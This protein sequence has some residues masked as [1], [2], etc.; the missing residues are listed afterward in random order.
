[1]HYGAPAENTRKRFRPEFSLCTPRQ[2]AGVRFG[3][4]ESE[5]QQLEYLPNVGLTVEMHRVLLTMYVRG[6]K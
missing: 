6:L 3:N 4:R 5:D 1:M 2:H